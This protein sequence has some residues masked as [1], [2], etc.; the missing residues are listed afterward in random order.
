[1]SIFSDGQ[2]YVVIVGGSLAFVGLAIWGIYALLKRP[3]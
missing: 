1:M 3:L 2:A